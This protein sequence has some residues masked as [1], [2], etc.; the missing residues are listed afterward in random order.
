MFR[1]LQQQA[2]IQLRHLWPFDLCQ[3][4]GEVS[5]LFTIFPIY[6]AQQVIRRSTPT[7]S[8]PWKKPPKTRLL[9]SVRNVT[10]HNLIMLSTAAV[11]GHVGDVKFRPASPI[12]TRYWQEPL[13]KRQILVLIFL[14]FYSGKQSN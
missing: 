14:A 13:C 5:S 12:K 10:K 1:M 2:E 6:N 11:R 3:L 9:H 4:L 7:C 8:T